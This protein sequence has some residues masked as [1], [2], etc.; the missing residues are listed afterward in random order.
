MD[1]PPPPVEYELFR[2]A[3]GP[4]TLDHVYSTL[5]KLKP[6]NLISIIQE[7]I[8]CRT[9]GSAARALVKLLELWDGYWCS[10][11]D[12]LIK[13]A[14][15][16]AFGFRALI[17]HCTDFA[18]FIKRFVSTGFTQTQSS[19]KPN[20]SHRKCE[21]SQVADPLDTD[22]DSETE[23]DYRDRY[24]AA[25]EEP[26]HS[27]ALFGDTENI[28]TYI[29]DF[30]GDKGATIKAFLLHLPEAVRLVTCTVVSFAI[31]LVSLFMGYM[32]FDKENL[33][34]A[35]TK[36]GNSL[37]GW[38]SILKSFGSF[39]DWTSSFI[40]NWLG[41]KQDSPRSHLV[42]K[43]AKL[44]EKLKKKLEDLDTNA[45][46]IIARNDFL[47][48]LEAEMKDVDDT[49]ALL[50][51][52]TENAGNMSTL[53]GQLKHSYVELNKRYM[54]LMKTVAG[55]PV[56]VTIW[57]YGES[58]VGKSRLAEYIVQQLSRYEM[59]PL[60]AYTRAK[61]DKYWSGYASQPV[62]IY[63]DFDACTDGIDHRELDAIYTNAAFLLNQAALPSKGMRFCSRYLIICSNFPFV[64]KSETLNNP[65]ILDRRRDFVIQCV[66]PLARRM[67]ASA[68]PAD[69]YRHDFSHLQFTRKN[70]LR[71]NN[72]L[73]TV[74]AV[75]IQ[76]IIAE[77][78]T[79]Q[80]T[81]DVEYRQS[82]EEKITI[83][84][85][86]VFPGPHIG[87][88][89]D[90]ATAAPDTQIDIPEPRQ[91]G[92][93][94]GQQVQQRRQREGNAMLDQERQNFREANRRRNGHQYQD[95]ELRPPPV[96]RPPQHPVPMGPPMA[97]IPLNVV[98]PRPQPQ[99]ELITA[100]LQNPALMEALQADDWGAVADVQRTI[101]QPQAKFTRDRFNVFLLFGQ[102][103]TGKSTISRELKNRGYQV[104]DEFA[105]SVDSLEVA[106]QLVWE[107]YDC[108]ST[109]PLVLVANRL[110]FEQTRV[111]ASWDHERYVAFM[112]RVVLFDFSFRRS[113][114]RYYTAGDCQE[115]LDFMT[116]IKVTVQEHDSKSREIA[117]SEVMT[118]CDQHQVS[119][120]VT[121]DYN[122]FV[123]F[124]PSEEAEVQIIL[125]VDATEPISQNPFYYTS[126]LF[127]IRGGDDVIPL[128]QKLLL[129]YMYKLQGI[130]PATLADALKM[131]AAAHMDYTE[132]HI[133]MVTRDNYVYHLFSQEG[134][135]FGCKL[136]FTYVRP[137]VRAVLEDTFEAASFLS[138]S[139]NIPILDILG[140][141]IRITV[142][143]LTCFLPGVAPK[144]IPEGTWS[145]EMDVVDPLPAYKIASSVRQTQDQSRQSDG[146]GTL[147]KRKKMD[148]VQPEKRVA[149]T[150]S[151]YVQEAK[152]EIVQ[153]MLSPQPEAKHDVSGHGAVANKKPRGLIMLVND[154]NGRAHVE[155]MTAEAYAEQLEK[156]A[157]QIRLEDYA[158]HLEDR[159][160][161]LR[162]EAKHDVS[163]HGVV[164]TK[165]KK[166]L[167]LEPEAAIDPNARNLVKLVSGNIV[168]CH[169]TP[170]ELC[171][172]LMLKKNVG[173][174]VSH[175]AFML[176]EIEHEGKRY[177]VEIIEVR[178]TKDQCYFRVKQCSDF[179]DITNHLISRSH[180]AIPDLTG[181][182]AY[183]VASEGKH[184]I[185]TH[186]V[187]I[188][189][190]T[191]RD[192][193]EVGTVQGLEYR[194]YLSGYSISPV[195][196]MR[197]DCGAPLI[198]CNPNVQKKLLGIH[199]AANTS[200]GFMSPIYLED[201][202]DS[203]HSESNFITILDHQ[204][205]QPFDQPRSVKDSTVKVFGVAHDGDRVC[206]AYYPDST[207]YYRSP[208][209]GLTVG[210]NSHEPAVLSNRDTRCTVEDPLYD[211]VMK[212]DVPTPEV[213]MELLHGCVDDI[214]MYLVEKVMSSGYKPRVL[215]KTEAINRCTDIPGSN[216][217]YRYS[218]AGYPWNHYKGVTR[219]SVFFELNEE[220]GI[221]TIVKNEL[222]NKL[223]RAIDQL[224]STARRGE[225]S[226]VVFQA[227]LKD[228]PLKLK[229]IYDTKT[230]SIAA[231][232]VDYTLA[233]RMYFHSVSAILTSI[234]TQIPIKIGINPLS[235]DWDAFYKWHQRAGTIG[236]D[237][238][239]KG[240]DA[241]VPRVFM[242][243]LPKIYNAIHKF[244][245]EGWLPEHDQV[246]T[247]L[248][249]CMHGPLITF[250][251]HIL[252]L[253]GGQPTGQPQTALDNSLINFIY[254]VY[255]W[256]KL[257]R[258]H[259]PKLSNFTDFMEQVSCS[260]YGDD[261][262]FTFNPVIRTWF[263]FD[264]YSLECKKLGLTVTPADKSLQTFPWK[265]LDS[266]SFLKR[267]FVT[268]GETN[269]RYGALE[270]DS[271]QRML[272]WA[273][274]NKPHR[275]WLEPDK[276]AYNRT[277][278]GDV[279]EEILIESA[280]HGREFF[281]MVRN[282]LLQCVQRYSLPLRKP[283]ITFDFVLCKLFF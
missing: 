277:L 134:K 162:E 25:F 6:I 15:F 160:A 173:V 114:F 261:N 49:F 53:I 124:P 247:H 258:T 105:N 84:R 190:N 153:D 142:G 207:K 33:S 179:P 275:F 225:R 7:V 92:N 268:L 169:G 143:S 164:A 278:I 152:K 208:F 120:E 216:P 184:M 197:G 79:L 244:C 12:T 98:L 28:V 204:H 172:A 283:L 180:G 211:A 96:L 230:R 51:K 191:V 203:L 66:E 132:R 157:R 116:K 145:D 144:L 266:L 272:D 185:S 201:V 214:A 194:G 238:D 257:A 149:S 200:L 16:L 3:P 215:T 125:D 112:R 260:F 219:K 166:E 14:S 85:T 107:A 30:V 182:Y 136:P 274:I 54:D 161:E 62:C 13:M 47:V 91:R 133:S 128:I 45:S 73:A 176:S 38:D 267:S 150:M 89:V 106:R 20:P 35:I 1:R 248:H 103:G 158:G 271:I 218:A 181:N 282:H 189:A 262:V 70:I 183:F 18:G 42:D 280:F 17:Q 93:R 118:Y 156:R 43:I 168:T 252:L 192:I 122:D 31:P 147:Y 52:T 240:W 72:V 95:V 171:R 60:L 199:I 27:Q 58:G 22:D 9:L 217:I 135:M 170:G 174:T 210:E 121:V 87:Q 269:Q 223:N 40:G 151:T 57:L 229:K 32:S 154:D 186:M 221:F 46:E 245:D 254:A 108:K 256:K 255:V 39:N 76:D 270:K 23:Y 202:P 226:C 113:F 187:I 140:L 71:E 100:Q 88:D 205:V 239:F 80:T 99:N 233:H 242:E 126:R 209:R 119:Q 155:H 253:S 56:P 141:F 251:Q 159:A 97:P 74:G 212:W 11:N 165:Q 213:D 59:K 178:K 232:P 127:V 228:E 196:T 279:T 110:T 264:S 36:L 139:V 19:T 237:C 67:D 55:K 188:S 61:D 222:G 123:P 104:M 82:L 137:H 111:A 50:A 4:T 2:P 265:P 26:M 259:N 10:S 5:N 220:K 227:C 21:D 48:E 94:A 249:S 224:I 281:E 83:F 241:T 246:R 44:H 193:V 250:H 102:P 263:N 75:S 81:R 231:S 276:I 198:V 130:R 29:S 117:Y 86:G 68:F 37:R 63:D 177:K 115:S 24:H 148:F 65:A 163:G 236:F 129:N 146:S 131:L 109:Q 167:Q 69:H 206:T 273:T 77:M 64:A 8:A 101:L 243:Q 235:Q 195:Q 234:H 138:H 175:V 34:G 41:L 78:F 90:P